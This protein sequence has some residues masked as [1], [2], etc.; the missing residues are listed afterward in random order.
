MRGFTLLEILVAMAIFTVIGLAS[1]AVLST[2]IDSDELSSERVEKLQALQRAM[3]TVERDILQA[4]ARPARIEGEAN[5]R[6]ILGGENVLDSDMDGLAFVRGG[7]QNPQWMLPR[8]T[9]QTV[10]Y[11]VQDNKLQRLYGN[12][13]DNVVGYEPKIRVILENVDDFQVE[14]YGQGQNS[15]DEPAA[16]QDSTAGNALPDAIAIEITTPEF[17]TIRRE[18]LLSH[19]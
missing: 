9:L 11:M 17:G 13:V 19:G 7:W 14:F 5:Q 15:P 16:W 10:G 8:S 18:F 12:Y 3:L 1:T 2:V 4:I 6:V